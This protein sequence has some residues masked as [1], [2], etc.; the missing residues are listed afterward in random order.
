[1]NGETEKGTD[2]LDLVDLG[3]VTVV[4]KQSWPQAPVY[5]DNIYGF[6]YWP[7]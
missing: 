6:S 3:D 5:P 1:M 4:T 2:V 7:Y